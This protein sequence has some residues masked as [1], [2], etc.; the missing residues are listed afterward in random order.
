ML[1]LVLDIQD[2][3]NLQEIINYAI[4][5]VET[6]GGDIT[7]IHDTEYDQ[8]AVLKVLSH[9]IEGEIEANVDVHHQLIDEVLDR[10]LTIHGYRLLERD[11]KAFYADPKSYA[12]SVVVEMVRQYLRE[13]CEA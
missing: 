8:L 9:R 1:K 12:D 13:H 6:S 3:Q 5:Q 11:W 10:Q 4:D 7:V 2:L